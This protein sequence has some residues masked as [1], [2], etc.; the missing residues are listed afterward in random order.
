MNPIRSIKTYFTERAARKSAEREAARI[1]YLSKTLGE[2]ISDGAPFE[3]IEKLFKDGGDPL[4]K[5]GSALGRAIYKNRE[6]VFALLVADVT[7]Q[8]ILSGLLLDSIRQH[9]Y[10]AFDLICPK[11]SDVTFR[12]D[13]PLRLALEADNRH[14]VAGLATLYPELKDKVT[15]MALARWAIAR[16]DNRAFGVLCHSYNISLEISR[17]LLK[18]A[19]ELKAETITGILKA[20]IKRNSE[21]MLQIVLADER[22]LPVRN[23]A[24]LIRHHIEL[25]ADPDF[26]NAEALAY[27]CYYGLKGCVEELLEAGADPTL[28]NNRALEWA[29][30]QKQEAVVALLERR[31]GIA[32]PVPAAAKSPAPPAP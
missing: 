6:D 16:D 25:G 22:E 7:D 17:D 30:S 20:H 24:A 8:K 18:I 1:E 31:M 4:Y 2:A 13:E 3:I 15:P 28:E 32:V 21:P 10:S 23:R 14:A 12:K 19:Q 29:K 26:N 5:N 11:V 9:R 27:A